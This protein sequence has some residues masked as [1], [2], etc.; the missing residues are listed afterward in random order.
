MGPC[1]S[2]EG[3]SRP[4]ISST[5]LSPSP[6]S[7]PSTTSS[8]FFLE[9]AGKLPCLLWGR[10]GLWEKEEEEEEEGGERGGLRAHLL[11]HYPQS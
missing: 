11:H 3:G 5:S 9:E 2:R 6:S 10:R 1:I 8:S 7:S 4:F